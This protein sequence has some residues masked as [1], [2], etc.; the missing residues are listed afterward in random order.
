MLPSQPVGDE[1]DFGQF[2]CSVDRNAK[3]IVTDQTAT[4]AV[5]DRLLVKLKQSLYLPTCTYVIEQQRCK[6]F[7]KCSRAITACTCMYIALPALL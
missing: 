3:A 6:G 5:Q 7:H 4:D 2:F 1:I